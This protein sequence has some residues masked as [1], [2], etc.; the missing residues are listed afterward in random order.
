VNAVVAS[1]KASEVVDS[2]VMMVP[3]GTIIPGG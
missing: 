2:P 1:V 3:G